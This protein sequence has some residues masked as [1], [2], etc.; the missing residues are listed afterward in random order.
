M[1]PALAP[2]EVR[3]EVAI[4]ALRLA[5]VGIALNAHLL[6]LDIDEEVGLPSQLIAYHRGL[7]SHRGN[8]TYADAATLQCCHQR[9]ESTIATR[10]E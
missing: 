3:R 2:N 4:I 1:R 6:L 5:M 8:Y 10:I 9:M 7:T